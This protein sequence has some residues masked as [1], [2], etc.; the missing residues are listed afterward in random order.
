VG[1][2]APDCQDGEVKFIDEFCTDQGMAP[3]PPTV[4]TRERRDLPKAIRTRPDDIE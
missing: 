2:C 4:M 1:S 3:V